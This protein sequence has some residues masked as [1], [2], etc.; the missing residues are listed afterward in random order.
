VIVAG[1]GSRQLPAWC[2]NL[3]T[4]NEQTKIALLSSADVFVAPNLARKSF[5]IVVLEAMASGVP[6]GLRASVVRRPD[7]VIP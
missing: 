5:G 1:A 3:G 6:C 4:I 2:R 7:R